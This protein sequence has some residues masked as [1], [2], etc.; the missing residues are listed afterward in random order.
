MNYAYLCTNNKDKDYGYCNRKTH[1][2]HQ[3]QR[4]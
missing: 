1:Q 2:R 4:T 3:P